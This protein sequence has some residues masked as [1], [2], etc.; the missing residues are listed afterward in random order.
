M[1]ENMGLQPGVLLPLSAAEVFKRYSDMVYRLAFSRAKS[2]ADAD[3]I[4]QEVFVRYIRSAVEFSE[5]EHRKS[6]FI[7]VTLRCSKNYLSSAWMRRT[8]PLDEVARDMPSV[9]EDYCGEVYEAVMQ[10]P[11]KYRTVVHLFYYEGYTITEI[12]QLCAMPE[13]TVKTH[14]YRARERIRKKLAEIIFAD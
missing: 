12:A 1:Q 11:T 4:L 3:D 2:R 14:L 10:L 13:A 6:W 8:V 9:Q 7:L 5:E